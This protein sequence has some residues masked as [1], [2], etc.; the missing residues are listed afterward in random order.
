M[1][2]EREGERERGREREGG[3][4]EKAL[5]ERNYAFYAKG[6]VKIHTYCIRCNLTFFYA[7]YAFYAE[8][9]IT[10]VL[11]KLY[12]NLLNFATLNVPYFER[13]IERKRQREREE[14]N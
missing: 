7:F 8:G 10:I 12:F 6:K 13:N 14:R 2:R 9:Q 1:E 5:Q 3:E 11:Y 4:R